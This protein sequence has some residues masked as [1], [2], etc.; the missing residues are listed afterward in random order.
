MRLL[1]TSNSA[2]NILSDPYSI[3]IGVKSNPDEPFD[4]PTK[5]LDFQKEYLSFGVWPEKNYETQ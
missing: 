1:K 5:P 2:V 3:T 4:S